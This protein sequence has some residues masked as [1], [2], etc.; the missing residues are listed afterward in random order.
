VLDGDGHYTYTRDLH[1][2]SQLWA[3]CTPAVPRELSVIATPLR[4][5][6]WE[7]ELWGHPDRE[8]VQLIIE[9]IRGGFRIGYNYRLHSRS[10]NMVSAS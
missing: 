10:R 3:A 1:K 7:S 6:A 5:Q 9:G 4:W 8:F 2:L